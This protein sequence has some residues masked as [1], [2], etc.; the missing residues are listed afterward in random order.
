M[1]R[2]YLKMII[3]SVKGSPSVRATY[4]DD[5]QAG[6]FARQLVNVTFNEL[7]R[8]EF[9]DTKWM[10]GGLI[11]MNTS[12]DEGAKEYSFIELEDVG[13]AEIVADNADDLP[14]ADILGRNN[15]R[16]IK[17][18]AVSVS[19]STQE[20]RTARLQGL[21][22]MAT[23]K[24]RAAREANDRRLDQ[25]IRTGAPSKG[26]FGVVN[27]PGI[28]VTPAITG[29]WQAASAANIIRDVSA[30]INA[31]INES[32]GVETPDTVLFDVRSFTRLSTLPFDPTS[33]PMTVLAF[34]RQA[35]PMIT[36]WDWEAGLKNVSP[37]AGPVMLVYRND[38]TR[39]R[40][41]FPMMMRALPPE[42][43]G[44]RIRLAFETRFGGVMTPRPRSVLLLTGV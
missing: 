22:D 38:P 30:A 20:I 15:V 21:F 37:S 2:A 16:E 11:P 6:L 14:E 3:D 7:F 33:G 8:H 13:M 42:Q 40:C 31:M 12:I 43:R 25:L 32:D 17:T 23:E 34:L 18:V 24:A 19:F 44:L 29:S 27:Q 1:N 28:I 26:L 35:F 36:R 39:M 41:V 5:A 4:H 10:N 9:P